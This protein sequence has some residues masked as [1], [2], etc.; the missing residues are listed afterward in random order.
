[1]VGILPTGDQP[2]ISLA[3]SRELELVGAFRFND[4]IDEGIAALA[5]G[6]SGGGPGDHPRVRH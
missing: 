2:V 1:M 5:D 4:E 3:I 6:E